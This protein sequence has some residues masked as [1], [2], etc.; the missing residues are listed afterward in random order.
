MLKSLGLFTR[1]LVKPA[2]A[3]ALCLVVN[4][5]ARGAEGRGG[6]GAEGQGGR[7]AE[8]QGGRGVEEL[9]GRGAEG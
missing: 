4:Q 1:F 2:I 5:A 9:R 3:I 7:G 6:R 8:G